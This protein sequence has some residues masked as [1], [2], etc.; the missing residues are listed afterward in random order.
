[1]RQGDWFGSVVE[2]GLLRT[3]AGLAPAHPADVVR[4]RDEPVVW[5]VRA[6]ASLER[7]VG[8][9]ERRLGDVLRVGRVRQQGERVLVDV[10]RVALVELFEG[11]VGAPPGLGQGRPFEGTRSLHVV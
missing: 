4:D 1:V 5:A 2:R 11:A 10:A 8:V 6:V 7:A 3:V 9:H